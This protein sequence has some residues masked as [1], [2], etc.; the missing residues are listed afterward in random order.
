MIRII[1]FWCLYRGLPD[2][3][4]LPFKVE[5]LGRNKG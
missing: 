4:K 5:G 1:L 2:L 3:E